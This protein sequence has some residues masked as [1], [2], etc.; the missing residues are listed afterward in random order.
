ML[1][2]FG[3]NAYFFFLKCLLLL[4]KIPVLHLFNPGSSPPQP[5]FWGLSLSGLLLLSK[6]AVCETGYLLS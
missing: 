1:T 4:W 6:G 2:S 5:H 3:S